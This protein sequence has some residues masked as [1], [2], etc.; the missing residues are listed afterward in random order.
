MVGRLSLIE[1]LD[2]YDGGG[3]PFFVEGFCFSSFFVG[4]TY[5]QVGNP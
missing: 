2:S 5:V 4:E 1:V 3:I